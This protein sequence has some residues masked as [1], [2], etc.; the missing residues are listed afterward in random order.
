MLVSAALAY[1]P[2]LP[3]A[4]VELELDD[5]R[6]TEVRV[7]MVA[8]GVCHTDAAVR[9]QIIPTPLPAVLGHEGAGVVQAVGS[10]IT[11]V[12]IGDHVVLGANSCG[13]CAQC[14][15]GHLAYCEHL[16]DRNFAARR[17]DGSTPFALDGRPVGG[18]FFG[19]SSFSSYANV[20]ERSLIRVDPELDLTLLAPLGCGIQTGAGAVLND[21]RPEPG[22]TIAIIG[23]GAVGSAAV[24]AASVCACTTII[25]I[26]VVEDRLTQSRS[27]GATHTI[28]SREDDIGERLRAITGGRG[29]DYILDTTAIPGLLRAAADQ[30]AIRGTLALVGSSPVGTEVRL[31][32]GASLNRG[33]TFKTIIQGSSVPQIF[34]PALIQLWKQGRFPFDRL[35]RHYP[36]A[37]I[38]QAFEDSERGITI[39]PVVVF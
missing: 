14:L 8:S 30:L 29:V 9:D 38:N 19:Q 18:Q 20:A 33:W 39:K 11:S 28:N 36:F 4:M 5:L 23:T 22:S 21:L 13:S 16:F 15:G 31:E 3:L 32:I 2:V 7:R 34:I 25:A 35:I 26:D 1:E 27:F 24:M 37:D 6:A 12:S 10:E 17:A